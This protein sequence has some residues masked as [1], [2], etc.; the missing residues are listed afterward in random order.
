MMAN[1]TTF[2]NGQV[3][4][5]TSELAH[6]FS[7]F[8]HRDNERALKLDNFL[9]MVGL[10]RR[11]A[12]THDTP[13]TNPSVGLRVRKREFLSST[14]PLG[15]RFLQSPFIVDLYSVTETFLRNFKTLGLRI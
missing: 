3:T 8:S 4:K 2:S 13:A 10:Q 15:G 6:P 14:P 7:E 1:L 5:M 12:R 11:K 9:Y